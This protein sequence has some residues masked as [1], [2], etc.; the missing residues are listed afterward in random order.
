MVILKN[1]NILENLKMSK[2]QIECKKEFE[3]EMLGLIGVL[4]RID[5]ETSWSEREP[6][7]W[8]QMQAVR[9]LAREVVQGATGN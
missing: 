7:W 5:G 1:E 3:R 6:K 9:K 2:L 8:L 4:D